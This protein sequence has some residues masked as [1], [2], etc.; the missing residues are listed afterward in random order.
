M[1]LNT[2]FPEAN[3]S[4]SPQIDL[5][6]DPGLARNVLGSFFGGN[7]AAVLAPCLGSEPANTLASSSL[8]DI[9][10][11]AIQ[12]LKIDPCQQAEWAKIGMIVGDIPM[13]EDLRTEFRTL[14]HP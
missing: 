7:R 3:G 13:Y 1:L 5:L 12:N 4:R 6:H 11:Q 10:K 14:S 8:H 2:G 9:V